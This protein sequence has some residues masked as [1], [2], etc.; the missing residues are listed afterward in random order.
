MIGTVSKVT[1]KLSK[2][3]AYSCFTVTATAKKW[4]IAKDNP[5]LGFS[6]FYPIC[7]VIVVKKQV[8]E[9]QQSF[10]LIYALGHLFLHKTS[11]IDDEQ[12]LHSHQ[13]K[14]QAAN[15]LLPVIYWCRILF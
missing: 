3:W 9:P 13:G 12:D 14:E 8:W 15:A 4:Q 6:L 10:T 1:A 11:S 5:I 2:H 7:P